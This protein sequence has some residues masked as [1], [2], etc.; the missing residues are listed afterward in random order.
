MRE[1]NK[2]P[3]NLEYTP[4]PPPIKAWLIYGELSVALYKKPNIIFKLIANSMGIE[5]RYE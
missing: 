5:V 4:D 2:T 3:F 1:I